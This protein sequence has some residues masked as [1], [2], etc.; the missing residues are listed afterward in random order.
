[1][2]SFFVLFVSFLFGIGFGGLILLSERKNL[3]LGGYGGNE[4]VE[5]ARREERI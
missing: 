1:V 3:K 5:E 4:D 2:F